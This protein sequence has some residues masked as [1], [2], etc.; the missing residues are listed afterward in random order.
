MTAQAM[1]AG[2]AETQRGSGR[3]PASAVGTADAPNPLYQEGY[4]MTDTTGQQAVTVAQEAEEIARIIR[5][6]DQAIEHA[7]KHGATEG[8]WLFG[9]QWRMVRAIL[10]SV[11]SASA[12]Y[13]LVPRDDDKRDMSDSI[14]PAAMID[15]GIEVL[16]KVQIDSLDYQAGTTTD[17]DDGMIAVAVYRAMLAASPEPVPA[18]NQAGEVDVEKIVSRSADQI[19]NGFSWETLTGPDNLRARLSMAAR[20]AV[21]DTLAALAT[22]PATSQEGEPRKWQQ[23]I[24]AEIDRQCSIGAGTCGTADDG[25]GLFEVN[26]SL[27]LN[28]FA[29]AMSRAATPTP[30]TLSEDLFDTCPEIADPASGPEPSLRE[31]VRSF[32]NRHAVINPDAVTDQY[33]AALALPQGQ[34]S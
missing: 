3:Q 26:A 18:T 29:Q 1:S 17:W 31:M 21:H 14:L 11:S 6:I 27:D 34:A 2:T 12:D 24:G 8:V 32:Y 5:W 4:S 20:Q 23:A 22:Q 30:P 19:L 15:A 28:G 25:S 9:S 33:F 16:D 10:G 7:K 13:V